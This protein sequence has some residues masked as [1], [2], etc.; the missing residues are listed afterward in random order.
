[1]QIKYAM[2]FVSDMEKAVAFY[3][4]TVGI[5]LRFQ[6]PGW[7]EFTTEGA[8]L[9][10]HRAEKS[11]TA[12]IPAHGGAGSCHPGFGVS[13]LDEF[14]QRMIA[15]GVRCIQEPKSVFGAKVAQYAAPDGLV[16]SVGEQSIGR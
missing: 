12:E 11:S 6:S 7:S 4:D 3:R 15:Q 5:P 10:L 14:H 1:M 2:I 16:F 9:A 13:S 8:T